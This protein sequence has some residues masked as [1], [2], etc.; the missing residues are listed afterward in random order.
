VWGYGEVVG[1]GHRGDL[2]R[3]AEA[4]EALAGV[5]EDPE[6]VRKLLEA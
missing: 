2:L 5:N 4:G 3:L 1:L 6:D